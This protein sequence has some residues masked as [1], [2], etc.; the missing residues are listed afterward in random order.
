MNTSMQLDDI[1]RLIQRVEG[2]LDHVIQ[3]LEDAELINDD[4]EDDEEL[5]LFLDEDEPE[6]G[7]GYIDDDIDE[8][9][10]Y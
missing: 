7:D 10:G 6:Y 2:K 4:D 8:D 1:I 5:D 9:R 3:L